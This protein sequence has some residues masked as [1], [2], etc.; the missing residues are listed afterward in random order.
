[1]TPSEQVAVATVLASGLWPYPVAI[2]LEVDRVYRKPFLKAATRV[3]FRMA[4]RIHK[5]S[6]AAGN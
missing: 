5:M 6:K 3:A 4:R 2:A 1:M